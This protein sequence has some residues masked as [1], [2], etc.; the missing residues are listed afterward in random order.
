LELE[1]FIGTPH[2]SGPSAIITGRVGKGLVENLTR[3]FEGRPLKNIVDRS[4][5]S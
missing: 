2:A 3:Y 4:E 5:Y 1:N